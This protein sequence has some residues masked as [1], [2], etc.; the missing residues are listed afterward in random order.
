ME[1][2]KNY[3]FYVMYGDRK[4]LKDPSPGDADS[5]LIAGVQM[6]Y[7]WGVELPPLDAPEPKAFSDFV[8]RYVWGEYFGDYRYE[9][10]NFSSEKA[11][12]GILANSSLILGVKLPGIPLPENPI[13]E[14]LML[15]PY[16][17]FEHINS[18]THSF[19]YQNHF[20]LAAGC[21][22]MPFRSYRYKE[23]EWLSKT[24]VF[25]EYV[26][27]GKVEHTKGDNPETSNSIRQDLRFGVA[28]SSRRY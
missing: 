20:F 11:Y 22:W 24:K 10:T 27:I 5:D 13:H 7:E 6:F 1:W 26:G 9:K 12:N 28:F 17:R 3:R 25:V 4:P 16:V 18:D 21:R 19:P 23:N 8:E 2:I 14:E 15:M